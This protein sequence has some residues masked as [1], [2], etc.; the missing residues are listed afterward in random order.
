MYSSTS[1]ITQKVRS[2]IT[3]SLVYICYFKLICEFTLQINKMTI[4]I[5]MLKSQ[6]SLSL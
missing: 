5:V 4:T 3:P 1:T 2:T 6:I